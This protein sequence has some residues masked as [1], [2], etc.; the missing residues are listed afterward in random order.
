MRIDVRNRLFILLTIIAAIFLYNFVWDFILAAKIYSF[1]SYFSTNVL[2]LGAFYYRSWALM[3]GLASNFLPNLENSPVVFLFAPLSF[4]RSIFFLPF[5]EVF[6]ISAAAIPV[7]FISLYWLGSRG[8]ALLLALIYLIYFGTAGITWFDVHYQSLFIPLFLSGYAF[9]LYGKWK[10]AALFLVLSGLVRFPYEIFP[11]AFGFMAIIGN[12]ANGKVKTG[13]TLTIATVIAISAGFLLSGFFL[14]HGDGIVPGVLQDAH[15]T[16]SGFLGNFPESIDSKIFTLFLMFGPFLMLPLL[17]LKWLVM[18]APYIFLL[19]FS[20]YGAY[21]FPYF[22]LVQYWSM[23]VPFLF[24]GAIEALSELRDS[25]RSLEHKQTLLHETHAMKSLLSPR[26]KVLLSIAIVVILLGTVYQPYGPLNSNS[27]ANFMIQD[28]LDH[29]QSLFNAYT[30][31]V[32]LIPS[33]TPYVLYQ[34]NMPEVIYH[35][36]VS[37]GSFYGLGFP[38]NYTYYLGGSW[39][40]HP[41]YII[42]DPY[43]NWFTNGGQGNYSASMYQTLRHFLNSTNYGIMAESSGI[44]LLSYRYAGPPVIYGPEKQTFSDERLSVS[45]PYYYSNGTVQSV[46]NTTGN[47]VWYGP[48]T[49]MQPGNYTLTLDLRASNISPSNSFTLRFSYMNSTGASRYIPMGMFGVTGRNLSAA[50]Q[51][52]RISFNIS[53]PNFLDYVEFAGQSFS[54]NGTFALRY[55]SLTQVSLPA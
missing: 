13:A 10:W 25:D 37:G 53:A 6:W 42:A 41:K 8:K 47:L 1:N 31:I 54:W 9:T 21:Y 5:L 30:D 33:N 44:I 49:F 39:I 15:S 46:D 24:I 36:P 19:F 4:Y 17:R 38:G 3:H 12:L 22:I 23:V 40:H 11:I 20:G 43:S 2:D 51:W 35:D 50:N 52:E 14:F 7:Y 45:M 32:G 27:S 28:E 48:Y 34:N 26:S 55:I 29:N 16:T 18:L